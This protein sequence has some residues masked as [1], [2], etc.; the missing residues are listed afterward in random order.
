LHSTARGGQQDKSRH[1]SGKG[2]SNHH[3]NPP[4]EK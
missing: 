1:C 3:K 4:V 2:I